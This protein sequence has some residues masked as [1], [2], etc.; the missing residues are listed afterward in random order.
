MS[1]E[2][3]SRTKLQHEYRVANTTFK[4]GKFQIFGNGS[5][6]FKLQA[7]NN[8]GQI[9][10]ENYLSPFLLINAGLPKKMIINVHIL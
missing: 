4:I 5:K 8:W 6:K 7:L 1:F 2:T 10:I 3:N 9:K